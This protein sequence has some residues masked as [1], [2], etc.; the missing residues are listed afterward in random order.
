MSKQASKRWITVFFVI[1]TGIG[2]VASMGYGMLLDG[3]SEQVILQENL[4]EYAIL[5]LGRDSESVRGYDALDIQSITESIEMDHGQAV[6]YPAAPL[7]ALKDSNPYWFNILWHAYTWLWFMAGVMAVYAIMRSLQMPRLIACATALF[8]YL[9]PRFFA[10]GHYNNKDILL[11]SLTLWTIAAA[12]RFW[13]KP[14][15]W[16]AAW[17]GLAGALAANIRIIGFFVFGV[18]GVTA[19]ITL[20]A[21]RQLDKRI[22]GNGLVA[23]VSFAA[24]Y[25]LITPAFMVNPGGFINHVLHNAAAFSRWDGLVIYKGAAYDPA[26][27]LSLPHSYLPTMIAFTVP[28]PVLVLA[29]LGAGCAVHLCITGDGRRPALLALMLLFVVPLG[30]AVLAQPLMYNGWR[31]FYFLYGPI[32]V[33]AGFGMRLLYQLL[34][35]KRAGRVVCAGVLA[36]ALLWQGIGIARNY[37]YEYAYYNE[38]A[39][40]VEG[41]FEL[42]YWEVSTLNAMR[43]LADSEECNPALPIVIGGGDHMS[44][45]SLLQ[46][47]EILPNELRGLI[48]VT[49]GKNPPYLFS[50][51]TYAQIYNERPG[52]KYQPLFSIKSYG[53]V[54]CTVYERQP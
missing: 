15:A 1:L 25:I 29:A 7:L 33:M 43:L 54:L 30:Y 13:Q 3:P 50:N 8:Y 49:E 28:I 31:H 39:G 37:P 23:I 35:K 47:V 34:W 12:I 52:A 27:G 51:T 24:V 18:M 11:L 36:G 42:D 46:N 53:N 26:N 19:L 38:L 45:F 40:T 32:L 17:F 4:K 9:S 6:Y 48:T 2:L 44:E 21:R 14:T 16:G 5:L 22:W 10:E 20:A 41:Q